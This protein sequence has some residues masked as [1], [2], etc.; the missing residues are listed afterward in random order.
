ME[1]RCLNQC[2]IF[3]LPA[4]QGSN[5]YQRAIRRISGAIIAFTCRNFL[6]I[7]G[8]FSGQR[9]RHFGWTSGGTGK[10]FKES[11]YSSFRILLHR[12]TSRCTA[13]RSFILYLLCLGRVHSYARTGSS[14]RRIRIQLWSLYGGCFSCRH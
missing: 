10:T 4:V 8:Y 5:F 9:C 3:D 12:D 7:T 14:G 13:T 1:Y 2:Y 6:H 11:S